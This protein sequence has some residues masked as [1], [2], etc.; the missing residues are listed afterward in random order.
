MKKALSLAVFL[1]MSLLLGGNASSADIAWMYV[2][3]REYGEGKSVNRLAF[4]L[5]D[6]QGRYLTDDKNIKE[7]K[8]LD[9]RGKEVKLSPYK[10]R[11]DEEIYGTYDTRNAQWIF[12][13]DWQFDSWFSADILLFHADC[14]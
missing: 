10:F 1:Y 8:L 6:D 3:H 13:K 9:L 2:Q 5:I 7:V 14:S 11:S 4:G 12:N